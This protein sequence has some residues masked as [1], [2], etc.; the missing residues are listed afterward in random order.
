ML[1]YQYCAILGAGHDDV[2]VPGPADGHRAH[3]A[4]A[5]DQQG[6]DGGASD[7]VP[8][9]HRVIA[10]AGHDDVAVPR[11]ADATACTQPL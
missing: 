4:L 2:A 6:A 11:P 3:P 1:S 7:R 10:G 5:A 9:P 8:D